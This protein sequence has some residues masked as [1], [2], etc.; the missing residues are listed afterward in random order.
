[1]AVGAAALQHDF[2]AGKISIECGPGFRCHFDPGEANL[3]AVGEE[4]RA[5]NSG[6]VL[7]EIVESIQKVSQVIAEIANA[8][9]EQSSGVDEINKALVIMDEVTQ[10]NSALV[11][12]NAA[13]AKTLE[14]QA[15]S[16]DEQVAFFQIDMAAGAEGMTQVKTVPAQPAVAKA[17]VA[18]LAV[19]HSKADAVAEA[20]ADASP[21]ENTRPKAAPQRAAAGGARRRQ[22]NL[23]TAVK[24]DVEWKEF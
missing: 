13:T 4:E 6:T 22:A 12:E 7:K 17:V 5:A 18:R 11:E 1:M 15:K 14:H 21:V 16:M 9:H 20:K 19:V 23:A 2:A 8:S 10:R 3:A 24:E